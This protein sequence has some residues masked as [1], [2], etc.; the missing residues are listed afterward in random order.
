VESLEAGAWVLVTCVIT[1]GMRDAGM[2]L[3]LLDG[4]RVVYIRFK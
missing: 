2:L 4:K 3:I 1:N